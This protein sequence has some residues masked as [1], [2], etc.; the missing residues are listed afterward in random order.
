MDLGIGTHR[1]RKGQNKIGQ[2][3]LQGEGG[4][5]VSWGIVLYGVSPLIE[6]S[7]RIASAWLRGAGVF[8]FSRV[9]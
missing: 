8:L 3:V 7:R 5:V 2:R 1:E 6:P 4:V 9:F